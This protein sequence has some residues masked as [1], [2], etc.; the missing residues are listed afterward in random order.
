MFYCIEIETLTKIAINLGASEGGLL[1]PEL[2][3][4]QFLADQLT[5]FQPGGVDYALHITT[6]PLP[7]HIFGPS[8]ASVMYKS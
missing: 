1:G 7:S 4:F 2:W 5:L 3:P 8:A 6:A